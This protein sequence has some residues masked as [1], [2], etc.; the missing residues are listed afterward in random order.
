[1][2]LARMLGEG[3]GMGWAA[4]CFSGVTTPG[5][6]EA[7][8][9]CRRMGFGR[10]IVFSFFLFTGVLEKRIRDTVATFAASHRDTE[11]LYAGYLG[12]HRLLGDVFRDRCDEALHGDPNMNCELCKYRVALPGFE[13]AVGAPQMGHHHHVRG[14]GQDEHNEHHVH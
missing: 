14:I 11:F 10:I 1:M 9:R 2:K 6:A 4:A 12:V 5:V 7:L 3:M 8:E 13:L